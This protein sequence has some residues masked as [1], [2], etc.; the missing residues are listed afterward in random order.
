[1]LIRFGAYPKEEFYHNRPTVEQ[2]K[3]LYG[4]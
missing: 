1:M 3:V 2:L 4:D